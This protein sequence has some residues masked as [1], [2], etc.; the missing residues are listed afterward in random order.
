MFK[1]QLVTFKIGYCD[2][3]LYHYNPNDIIGSGHWDVTGV[4]ESIAIPST[5]LRNTPTDK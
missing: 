4:N 2:R 5:S 3:K 1:Q